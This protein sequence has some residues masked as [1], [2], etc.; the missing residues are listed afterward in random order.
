MFLPLVCFATFDSL[1]ITHTLELYRFEIQYEIVVP[2]IPP[3]IIA[4][5]NFFNILDD[6]VL[7]FKLNMAPRE[8][9]ELSIPCE[10]VLYGF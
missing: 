3:P 1:S 2:K 10:N 9:F 8:R 4:I 6:T 7:D 5:S